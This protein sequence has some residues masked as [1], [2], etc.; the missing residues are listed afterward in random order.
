MYE[1]YG[2]RV[3]V[4]KNGNTR[5]KFVLTEEAKKR[6]AAERREQMRKRRLSGWMPYVYESDIYAAYEESKEQYC[7]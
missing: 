7:Y 5:T 2:F 4:D 6:K 3:W 1:A